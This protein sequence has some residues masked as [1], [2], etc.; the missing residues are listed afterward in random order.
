[1][2]AIDAARALFEGTGVDALEPW[3]DDHVELRPPT[4]GKSW[5]GKALVGRLLVFAARSMTG[6]RYTDVVVKDALHVLRF[7]AMVGGEPISGVDLVRCDAAGKIIE[8]EIF[9]R[10]PR[11]VLALRDA[12]TE[13][14]RGDPEVARLM[15]LPER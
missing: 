15:S 9:A 14:V 2:T 10:P 13:H 8:F 5:R 6:F 7:E 12:M 4:Y 3:L 1:M 11:A